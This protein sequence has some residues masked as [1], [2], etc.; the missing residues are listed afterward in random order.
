MKIFQIIQILALIILACSCTKEQSFERKSEQEENKGP[1]LVKV[2]VQ[3]PGSTYTVIN[4]FEYDDNKRLI[5]MKYEYDGK[6][7]AIHSV[8]E[9]NYM[10]DQNGMIRSII[11][12]SIIYD[13][14]ETFLEKYN[15]TTNLVSTTQG[16]YK[17]GIRTLSNSFNEK[18]TDS[19][20]YTYNNKERIAVTDVFRK[21]PNSS[22]YQRDQISTYL[23]DEKGNISSITI[24]FSING[25]DPPQVL[26][27]Q[28]NDKLP[29]ANWGD[30]T[31]LDGFFMAGFSS[32][33]NLIAI[34]DLSEP[35][36]NWNISYE[37]NS[38]NKPEKGVYYNPVTEEKLFYSY[39]YQ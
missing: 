16:Q 32:P 18:I 4:N 24:K 5:K 38:L 34:S 37:Y 14:N 19:I 8:D 25:Q 2:T 3:A 27:F 21:D 39:F 9:T 15:L 6:V 36:E 33:N 13:E 7:N 31:L 10:R 11:G 35:E 17:F 23:Y 28:Y 12:Q 20:S 22:E 26:N 1:L 29:A 30:E